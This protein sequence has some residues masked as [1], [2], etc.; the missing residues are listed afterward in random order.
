MDISLFM[1]IWG[2]LRGLKLS[3]TE[4][5]P[6]A[7]PWTAPVPTP[8]SQGNPWREPPRVSKTIHLGWEQSKQAQ[9]TVGDIWK[10]PQNPLKVRVLHK[11]AFA[12]ILLN[13]GL[14]LFFT[15]NNLQFNAALYTY[16]GASTILLA[17]YWGLTR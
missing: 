11:L 7:D 8:T 9:A 16:L 2:W 1:D 12:V 17:H 5:K 4:P 14:G 6:D 3:K 13:V 10:P 15:S